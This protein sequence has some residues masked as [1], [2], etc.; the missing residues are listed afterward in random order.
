MT[1][2]QTVSSFEELDALDLT[3]VRSATVAATTLASLVQ[4]HSPLTL[5]SKAKFETI[6]S[7]PLAN[8]PLNLIEQINQTFTYLASFE[9]VRYLLR[10]H[11]KHGPFHLNL[12]NVKGPDIYSS[13]GH[14][15]AEVFAAVKPSNN[16][17]LE[18]DVK[19]LSV[20][21]AQYRYVFYSCAS[22]RAG[23]V[24]PLVDCPDVRIISLG[25]CG[26]E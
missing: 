20:V 5:L 19:K 1:K 12:G 21:S 11:S 15:V 4:N 14:V 9:A 6:G 7:D 18:K 3:I 16:R 22:E 2:R 24:A 25:S 13:D 17:K 26:P 10:H 8:H 23:E